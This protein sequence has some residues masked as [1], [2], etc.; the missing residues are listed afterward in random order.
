LQG[1]YVD[2]NGTKWRALPVDF[3]EIVER[4][5][6]MQDTPRHELISQL[7]GHVRKDNML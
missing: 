1:R 2:D 3:L 6:D 4:T 7:R 5:D